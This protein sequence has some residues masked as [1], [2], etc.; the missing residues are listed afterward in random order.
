MDL[1]RYLVTNQ[2]L[3]KRWLWTIGTGEDDNCE[4][5]IA[6][7]VIRLRQCPLIR[8]GKGRREEGWCREVAEF[9]R[10]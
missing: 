3:L 5:G 1:L 4:C 8:D 6:Q 2:G 9:L 7:D 10:Y